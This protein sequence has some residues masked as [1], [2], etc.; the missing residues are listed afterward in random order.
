MLL[1]PSLCVALA[2]ACLGGPFSAS[3]S[4]L[5]TERQVDK[6]AAQWRGGDGA[7][8]HGPAG[9][10][11]M[12]Y[13][14][15]QP[16]LQCKPL[17]ICAIRLQPGERLTEAPT[18]GD[19]V[20]WS[21]QVRAGDV[22]GLQTVYIV[23]KPDTTAQ[24][25]SLFLVTDRRA[26]SIELVPS[27]RGY[28]PLLSFK[29]PGDIEAENKARVVAMRQAAEVRAAA[30]TAHSL[31]V[32]GYEIPAANLDFNYTIKGHA[33]FRPARIFNDGHKTY[34]DLPPGYAGDMPVFLELAGQGRGKG[35]I[36]NYRIAGQRYIIDKVVTSGELTVGVG[37]QT[38]TIRFTQG[39][40]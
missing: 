22:G 33:A 15:T 40:H 26:Y 8:A 25:T 31:V 9:A 39:G 34:I 36:V 16:V 3:A 10:V 4:S 12:M 19:S 14:E 18:V 21:V 13:G 38:E 27:F 30:R 20:R 11:A 5:K 32:Q 37:G 6:L 1:R 23:A 28:T 7:V 2:V 24:R 17:N 29:Y 35:A